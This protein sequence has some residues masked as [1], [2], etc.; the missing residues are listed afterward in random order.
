MNITNIK[1]TLEELKSEPSKKF[2]QSIDAIFILKNLDLKKSDHQIDIFVELTK[3][4]G[5]KNKICAIVGPELAEEAKRVCDK[6]ILDSEFDQYKKKNLGK[7]LAREF[8]FFIGQANI[9]PKIAAIFGRTLGPKGKMPNPKAGCILP[10][11]ATIEPL[12]KKLQ[13]TIR[14]NVKTQLHFSVSVGNEES[15]MDDVAENI[16]TLYN[17]IAKAV[18]QEKEN[19]K[20]VCVKKTMSK[21]HAIDMN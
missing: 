15:N 16:M 8:D 20:K 19:I 7:K 12:F 21:L 13:K 1:K 4:R 11:K 10:P 14:I 3:D 18:A 17:G 9:M 6:V 2:K 5:R